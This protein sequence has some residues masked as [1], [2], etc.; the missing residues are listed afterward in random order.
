MET[1]IAHSIQT[2][3]AHNMVRQIIAW[4]HSYL[5]YSDE[6]RPQIKDAH[7]SVV[8]AQKCKNLYITYYR[9]RGQFRCLQPEDTA[10]DV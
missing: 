7:S 8:G 5:L 2:L 10:G 4:R 3:T 9:W 1:P 6:H